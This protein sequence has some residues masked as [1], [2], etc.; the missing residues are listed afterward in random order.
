MI[1]H[2]V[3]S[4][5]AGFALAGLLRAQEAKAEAKPP[6]PAQ[7]M[8]T[9]LAKAQ[10][11]NKRVLAAFL[12][13]EDAAGAAIEA[14]MKGKEFAHLLLYEFETASIGPLAKA[15]ADLAAK[16]GVDPGTPALVV[17]DDKGKK[18]GAID[19]EALVKD[20]EVRTEAVMTALKKLTC[21]PLD[22]EQ[23]LAAALVE[24]KKAD[25]R[26]L[27]TFDAPW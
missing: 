16:Y 7:A 22:G 24:V 10:K 11:H 19:G 2:R 15:G 20:G 18:L 13:K 5:L 17:L 4:L 3:G 27:L 14:A 9:A 8:A 12:I 21:A 23:V 6:D 1:N 26:L 25:K